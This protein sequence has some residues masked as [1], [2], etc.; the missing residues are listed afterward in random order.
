MR[1]PII[2]IVG[3]VIMETTSPVIG[4]LYD[5]VRNNYAKAIIAG[6]G[7]P[8]YLPV[9]QDTGVIQ[10]YLSLCDGLL[11]PGGLD[12]NPLYYGEDPLPLLELTIPQMDQFQIQLIQE[13]FKQKK[14]ML[15]ICRGHQIM[16][17][18]LGGTLYQDVSY[19]VT[20]P[21][22]HFQQTQLNEISHVV[23]LTP[24]SRLSALF[25]SEVF[26]NSGHHQVVK[27]VP[28]Q[29]LVTAV[30]TDGVIEAIEYTK[31]CF[32]LGVQWHP[33]MMLEGESNM[34]PLF[35]Q[36]I[37]EAAKEMNVR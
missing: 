1:K 11:V 14:V 36:L 3:T 17:V 33:E 31:D 30:A 18:A 12:I 2:G 6:G 21:L 29:F 37:Q 24:N 25:G 13:A 35:K 10:Y 22:Q 8:V 16:A 19:A 32:I 20:F 4:F 34:I 7:I 27:G 28:P 26:V 15:G 5:H 23:K 9:S